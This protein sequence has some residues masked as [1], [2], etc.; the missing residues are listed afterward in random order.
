MLKFLKNINFREGIYRIFVLMA[1]L[2]FCSGFMNN[3][4]YQMSF[5]FPEFVLNLL[6]S[7]VIYLSFFVFDWVISGFIGEDKDSNGL[8]GFIRSVEKRISEHNYTVS[9]YILLSVFVV[10]FAIMCK[11]YL[12]NGNLQK[13]NNTLRSLYNQEIQKCENRYAF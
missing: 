9:F 4:Y 2:N 12:E 8:K 11:F 13:S 1:F 3:P 10:V 7:L 6:F 5:D